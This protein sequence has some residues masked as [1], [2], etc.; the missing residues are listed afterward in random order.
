[1]RYKFAIARSRSVTLS[2]FNARRLIKRNKLL[3]KRVYETLSK[4]SILASRRWRQ[5][6]TLVF[7]TFDL[8]KPFFQFDRGENIIRERHQRGLHS[9]LVFSFELG[10]CMA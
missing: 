4:M 10:G 3:R 9:G 8:G 7:N 1:M 6:V 5:S 2:I